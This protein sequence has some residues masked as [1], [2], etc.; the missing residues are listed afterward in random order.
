MHRRGSSHERTETP[1]SREWH[2]SSNQSSTT[3][4]PISLVSVSD[5][6]AKDE[7]CTQKTKHDRQPNGPTHRRLT[8]LLI[9]QECQHR[10]STQNVVRL[11]PTSA[12]GLMMSVIQ[13]PAL[14]YHESTKAR[15]ISSVPINP[16]PLPSSFRNWLGVPGNSTCE[17][18][19]SRLTSM[20]WAQRG[21]SLDCGSLV[22]VN[23]KFC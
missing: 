7:P 23:A 16:S 15:C 9:D 6:V 4:I 11:S 3:S 14:T 13:R 20:L 8:G 18:S 22:A 21:Q 19:P 17:I 5:R 2:N 1:R 12:P 10:S